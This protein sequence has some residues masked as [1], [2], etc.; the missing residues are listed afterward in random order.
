MLHITN[1]TSL[2]RPSRVNHLIQKSPHSFHEP[3]SSSAPCARQ[4]NEKYT[5][6]DL[7]QP[8]LLTH[9]N[10]TTDYYIPRLVSIA[11]RAQARN[12]LP[13]LP[14]SRADVLHCGARR[15][16]ARHDRVRYWWRPTSRHAEHRTRK[17][18]A[19]DALQRERIQR[20]CR[21]ANLQIPWHC[22]RRLSVRLGYAI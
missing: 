11:N 5:N 10:V 7:R 4:Q 20:H 2:H 13:S 17:S 19:G 16:E 15:Q 8:H 3:A 1:S 22:A 9:R 21:V 18:G 14:T 12:P 6:Q